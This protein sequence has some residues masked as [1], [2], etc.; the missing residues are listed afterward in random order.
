MAEEDVTPEGGQEGKPKKKGKAFLILGLLIGLGGGGVAGAYFLAP[1]I[2]ERLATSEATGQDDGGHGEEDGEAGGGG[3]DHGEEESAGVV[4]LVDNLVVNPAGSNGS[5]FLL[6]NVAFETR[7]ASYDDVITAR[8]FQIRDGLLRVL[9]MKT[10]AELTDYT[11]REALVQELEEAI[12][13]V[14]GDDS[15]THIYLPQYVIQ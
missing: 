4:H 8:E 7:D 11:L 6:A 13:K 3:G 15:V 14:L 9:G 1:V 5:R 12:E 2:G 10:V